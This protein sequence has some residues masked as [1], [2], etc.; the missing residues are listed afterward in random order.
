M[1][2]SIDLVPL[3]CVEQVFEVRLVVCFVMGFVVQV[4]LVVLVV[5]SG[6]SSTSGSGIR[7]RIITTIGS[8][9]GGGYCDSWN[10]WRG[11][12]VQ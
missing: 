9:K 3:P 8:H 1:A 10:G 6:L 11:R 5:S 12:V 2:L 4:D 7:G